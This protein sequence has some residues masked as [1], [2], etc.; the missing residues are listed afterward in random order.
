VRAERAQT[1]APL[2]VATHVG[3]QAIPL[4]PVASVAHLVSRNQYGCMGARLDQQHARWPLRRPD[5]SEEKCGHGLPRPGA[6][7]QATF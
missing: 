1:I 7:R 5:L 6:I 4:E 2:S 3:L